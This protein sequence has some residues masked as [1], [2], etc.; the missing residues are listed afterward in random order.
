MIS[1]MKTQKRF[2]Y[3]DW[4]AV[5]STFL[6]VLLHTIANFSE[7][8]HQNFLV[9]LYRMI[10]E[11][12][13]PI[14][15]MKSGALILRPEKAITYSWVKAKVLHTALLI[16]AW[17]LFYNLVS[18]V[19]I[20]G[21]SFATIKR[22]IVAIFVGDTQYN[23]QFW[24]LYMLLGLY[25]FTPVL[26][27]FLA[28][29]QKADYYYLLIISFVVSSA[30][31]FLTQFTPP[32]FQP[33]WIEKY[34]SQFSQFIFYFVLGSYLHQF[35][36]SKKKLIINIFFVISLG[37]L[38]FCGISGKVPKT[39]AEMWLQYCYP[40]TIFAAALVFSIFQKNVYNVESKKNNNFVSSL[41]SL[42]MGIYILHPIIIMA[43][44]KICRI[45]E[46]IAYPAISIPALALCIYALC[47]LITLIIKKVPVLRN[48]V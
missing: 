38:T 35:G 23:Y 21:L 43:L 8:S 28:S 26:K 45:D 39:T 47:A 20:Y 46:S 40:Y 14:F 30:V 24:Y 18:N 27:R 2:A 13:V 3:L 10:A 29:S 15:I 4:L 17:G 33:Y 48:L 36:M 25:A 6:V 41:S 16:F 32:R 1:T 19:I 12:A 37:F 31:P 42:G 11:I 7:S 44:R 9:L 34:F 22:S 5:L